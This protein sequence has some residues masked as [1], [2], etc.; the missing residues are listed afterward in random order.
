MAEKHVRRGKKI[1]AIRKFGQMARKYPASRWKGQARPLPSNK[2]VE[3]SNTG[4][5]SAEK[6]NV[7]TE[8]K[9]RNYH[10]VFIEFTRW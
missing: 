2:N 1:R 3:N 6:S 8:Q 9:H 10:V 5:K 7:P 4:S